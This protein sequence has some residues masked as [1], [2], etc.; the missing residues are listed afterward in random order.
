VSQ[1][2]QPPIEEEYSSDSGGLM[3]RLSSWM[4]TLVVCSTSAF[5]TAG[6]INSFTEVPRSDGNNKK[7]NSFAV[8]VSY[9]LPT[10]ELPQLAYTP[11][12]RKALVSMNIEEEIIST[13][14]V[15]VQTITDEDHNIQKSV[16]KAYEELEPRIQKTFAKTRKKTIKLAREIPP[17]SFLDKQTQQL[18]NKAYSTSAPIVANERTTAELSPLIMD[19]RLR[20]I[21]TELPKLSPTNLLAQRVDA[22]KRL[23]K[24]P[25]GDFSIQIMRV[26]KSTIGNIDNFIHKNGL[27]YMTDDLYMFPL[28]NQQYLIYYG[29]F[30]RAITARK[31]LTKLP[32]A[33]QKSGAFIIPLQTI[34][35]KTI[36]QE[37]QRQI[38]TYRQNIS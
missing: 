31:A 19:F 6:L 13:K 20:Y 3:S 8:G 4:V 7:K 12:P 30:D 5:L 18:I 9:K 37:P 28:K 14:Q 2:Q 11:E 10:R 1:Q 16:S 34:R 32:D 15:V 23:M 36:E 27:A 29:R 33:I 22:G 24:N 38:A 17:Q 26:S 35:A 25:D 21:P